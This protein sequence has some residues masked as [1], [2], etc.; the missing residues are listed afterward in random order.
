MDLCNVQEVRQLLARHG[1]HFS[2]ARGQNFLVAPW[3]PR[4]IVRQ[5]GVGPDCGVLEIGPGIGPL[6]RELAGQAA[7]VAAVEVDRTLAPVLGETLGEFANVEVLWQDILQVDIPG[8]VRDRFAGLRPMA[9]AN[10]PYYITTPVVTALLEARC[11]SAVTVMVQKEVAQRMAA[12]PGTQAYGAF[13]LFCQYY[14]QPKLLFDVPPDCFLP[15]PK[16]TSAVVQLSVRSGPPCPVADEALFFRVVRAA[17]GQRRKQL[18]NAL[19]A[20][21]PRL[22]KENLSRLL[23]ACGVS[24]AA[25]G[26]TLDIAAFA[27]IANALAEQEDG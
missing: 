4:E 7:K 2:K 24:P 12:R 3:V 20:G 25:R 17:F 6:T 19:S 26:E 5:S 27:R 1:F 18:Q 14:A 11:F 23:T 13:S 22:G 16:I 10:L 21:F 9:C 15:R 8:L